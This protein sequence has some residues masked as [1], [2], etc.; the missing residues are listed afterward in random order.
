MSIFILEKKLNKNFWPRVILSGERS[1]PDDMS[2]AVAW[3]ESGLAHG[4]IN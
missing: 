4:Q 2:E 3:H 1:V